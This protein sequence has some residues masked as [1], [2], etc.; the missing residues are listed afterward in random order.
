MRENYFTFITKPARNLDG[1]E[2]TQKEKNNCILDGLPTIFRTDFTRRPEYAPSSRHT[3]G[4]GIGKRLL[5]PRYL[6]RD[7]H[8][9]KTRT[10]KQRTDFGKY[11]FVNRTIKSCNQLHAV[12]LASFLCKLTLLERGLKV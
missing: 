10:R 9:R 4:D 5:K 12:L 1:Y 8:N 2:N 6:S 7:D 3:P 11:S